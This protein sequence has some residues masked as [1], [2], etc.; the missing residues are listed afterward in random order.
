MQGFRK[1]NPDRWE[2][3]NEA[4]LAGQ[5]NLLKDI[6][7]RRPSKHQIESELR[8]GTSVCHGQP[9]SLNE[10]DSLKRD[11]AALRAEIITLKRQYNICKSQLI[12]MEQRVLNNERKQE[13]IITFFAKALSNP[14][15]VQQILS[16][17]TGKKELRST[18]KGQ[19]LVEN[20]EQHVV[21]V[22]LK[23]TTSGRSDCGTATN[24]RPMTKGSDQSIGNMCDDVWEELDAIPGTQIKQEGKFGI[25]V[26]NEEFTQRPCG[27]IDEYPYLVEP[28]QF[29][30]H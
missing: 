5:K 12:A 24:G 29:V 22:L 26:D 23:S 6:R 25:N 30:E 19:Q 16:N 7:R 28:M 10:V 17:Y 13:Q 15:F 18:A 21:D 3:A 20:E 14:V 4:F 8:Y 2:F 27:W 1:V 9:E 11:G